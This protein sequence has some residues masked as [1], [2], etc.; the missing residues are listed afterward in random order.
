MSESIYEWMIDEWT[1]EWMDKRMKVWIISL[2][3]Y[4]Y[5]SAYNIPVVLR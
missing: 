4:V 1:E 3:R 2:S 5:F